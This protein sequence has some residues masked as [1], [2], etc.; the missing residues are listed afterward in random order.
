MDCPS[1]QILS[2]GIFDSRVAYPKLTHSRNRRINRFELELITEDM[3]GISYIDDRAYPLKKGLF[4]CGKPGQRRHSQL[5]TRCYYVHLTT[6]DPQLTQLLERLPDACQL[7]DFTAMQQLFQALAAL[8]FPRDTAGALQ[9]QSLVSTLIS[10]ASRQTARELHTDRSVRRSHRAI[11]IETEGYI[12]GHL[13]EPLTLEQLS[14]RVQF[15]PSHFHSIFTAWFG[16]TP[17]AFVMGCRIEEA[18]AALRSDRS[19]LI[20]IASDCG[21]SSQSHFSAQ[22]KQATGL[23]PLQYRKAKLSR[24]EP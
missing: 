21:F 3:T 19:G 24:L 9:L 20:E 2:Y 17:H 7:S 23:T 8:P 4:L 11:M 15:S 14:R 6:E 13:S 18:K 5:P 16:L 10:L 12:R 22:F 1:Y